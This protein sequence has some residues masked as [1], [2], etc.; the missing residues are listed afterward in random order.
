MRKRQNKRYNALVFFFGKYD[1]INVF[2]TIYFSG[3]GRLYNWV[4]KGFVFL[5]FWDGLSVY[6]IIDFVIYYRHIS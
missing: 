2:M 1:F 3:V 4:G 6:C 5:A